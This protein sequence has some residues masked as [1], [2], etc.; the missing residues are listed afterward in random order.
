MQILSQA[1]L[2]FCCV[3]A[4]HGEDAAEAARSKTAWDGTI[5]FV[6]KGKD[7]CNLKVTE[8]VEVTRLRVECQGPKASYWC[9]S[10][11]KPKV[12]R[13]YIANPRHFFTQIMWELRKL[14]NACN[15]QRIIK[16]P[17]CKKASDEAQMVMTRGASSV[18]AT[19][20][21]NLATTQPPSA[22]EEQVKP[23]QTKQEPP[24]PAEQAKPEQAKTNGAKQKP[25]RQKPVKP[26]PT[27]SQP[28]RPA[29]WLQ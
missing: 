1:V 20:V 23:E 14:Q 7:Q 4:A 24:S 2:L 27:R 22:K 5:Q 8:H 28:A 12:C 19:A 16:P 25:V 11:G 29:K 17:M 26:Q 3:W 6:T 18:Q 9:E 13:N 21:S 10:E 15:G